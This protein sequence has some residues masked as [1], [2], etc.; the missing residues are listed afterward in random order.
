M[1]VA[2]VNLFDN[3]ILLASVLLGFTGIVAAIYVP[4]LNQILGTTPLNLF[5]WLIVF[6][7]GFFATL[8]VEISKIFKN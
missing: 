4:F 1:N 6:S 3:K 5:H 2:V 7:V 8:I